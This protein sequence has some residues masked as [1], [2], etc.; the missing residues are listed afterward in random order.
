MA[1]T[2]K[3]RAHHALRATTNLTPAEALEVVRESTGSVKGGGASLLTSG[4]QNVGAMVQVEREN[5][6]RLGLSVTSGRRLVELCTF[7]AWAE[8]KD[9]RTS[10]T[11]G[12]LETYKTTQA[13][14]LGFIPAGPK[15]IAGIDI[16]K[17]FLN[18]VSAGLKSRDPGA[19]VQI[20]SLQEG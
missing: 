9:G 11:V 6:S 14:V 12:G 8:T 4:I 16:Y 17:R 15:A 13:T 20:N 19:S 7:P 3:A 18:A 2:A 1:V 5:E 10:L